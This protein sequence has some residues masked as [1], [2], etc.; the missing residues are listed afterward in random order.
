MKNLTPPITCTPCNKKKTSYSWMPALLVAIL[1][2]CPFCVMAYSGA[3][4]MCSGNNLYPNAG[5][6]MSYIT[7][8]LALI[9]LISFAFNYKGSKTVIAML[10]AM[11]G[12]ALLFI[13]QI[14]TMSSPLYYTAVVILFFGIWFNGS[15][16]H[17]FNKFLAKL[18][19][20]NLKTSHEK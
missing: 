13:S 12:V 18:K 5:G 6:I 2:K 16:F 20:N 1:P 17:F 8:G 10:I 14:Y 11:V 15:F 19:S 4:S 3:I 7:I 9:V